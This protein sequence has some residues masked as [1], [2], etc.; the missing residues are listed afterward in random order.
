[1]ISDVISLFRVA[2]SRSLTMTENQFDDVD[3]ILT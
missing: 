2:L 1:M 3:S